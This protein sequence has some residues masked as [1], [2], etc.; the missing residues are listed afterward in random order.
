MEKQDIPK[1][2][3]N[4]YQ[5]EYIIQSTRKKVTKKN[6]D[7]PEI[8]NTRVRKTIKK[9]VREDYNNN[10]LKKEKYDK[11]K[12]Y[13][14]KTSKYST[15]ILRSK[16]YTY[17]NARKMMVK[18][19]HESLPTCE[20]INNIVKKENRYG[21]NNENG[22]YTK[23]YG[24][25]T[26]D[27]LCPCCGQENETVEHLFAHCENEYIQQTRHLIHAGIM[28]IMKKCIGPGTP[29]PV[30]F[31]YDKNNQHE[32]ATDEWD[33][34]LVNLG[35]FPRKVEQYVADLLDEDNKGKLKYIMSDI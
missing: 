29:E 28:E 20:K 24:K 21:Y 11:L 2:R 32:E 14:E 19:I 34:S 6:L 35:I 9:I 15:Q 12:K 8:I 33:L 22:F 17:E 5:N 27:G 25:Y 13:N 3:F 30:T 18:M 1:S 31:F 16:M 7:K 26:N 4:R 10:L 23:R